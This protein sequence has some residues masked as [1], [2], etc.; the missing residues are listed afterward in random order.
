MATDATQPDGGPQ[1]VHELEQ[2]RREKRSAVAALGLPIYGEA[3]SGLVSLAAAVANYDA[4]ADD[5]FK[6]KGKEPGYADRRP[7]VH[8]AGR[9]MLHR[10]NG[11]LIWMN[12][13]DHSGDL[14]IAVSQRECDKAGFDLTKLTDLGDVVVV[15]G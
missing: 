4:A 3:E 2:Q 1:S 10:D 11:K 13:R 12:L 6:A 15:A 14:Q 8:V 9:V 5:E 7:V